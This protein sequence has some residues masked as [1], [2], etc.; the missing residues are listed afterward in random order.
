MIYFI[1]N[2][3]YIKIGYSSNPID[4]IN[5]IAEG[6]PFKISIHAIIEGDEAQEKYMQQLFEKYHVNREWFSFSDEIKE[7]ITQ[8]KLLAEERQQKKRNK[9]FFGYLKQ[10]RLQA[11]YTLYSLGREMDMHPTWVD[12]LERNYERGSVQLKR[13]V[14]YLDAIGYE[15]KIVKKEDVNKG[16]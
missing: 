13:L 1:G 16:L 12:D 9:K 4:R 14:K 6:V 11:G 10:L 7:F 3:E 5:C 2:D 8:Q 15:F